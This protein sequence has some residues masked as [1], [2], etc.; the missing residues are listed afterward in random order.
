MRF[1][2]PKLMSTDKFGKFFIVDM[3]SAT[4]DEFNSF[5][6]FHTIA[7]IKYQRMGWN[8]DGMYLCY[9]ELPHPPMNIIKQDPYEFQCP[10]L[11]NA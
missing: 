11:D 5:P 9:R 1:V 3:S 8:E 10:L 2:D 6:K 7:D 4:V